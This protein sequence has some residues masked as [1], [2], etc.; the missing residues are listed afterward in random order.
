MTTASRRKWGIALI[1]VPPLC[2][3]GSLVLWP[4]LGFV[5][6]SGLLG[7]SVFMARVMNVLLGLIGIVGVAGLFIGVPIGL[8]LVF[9][10][11]KDQASPPAQQPPQTPPVV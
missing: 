8:Y 3:G 10:K 7:Y 5:Y 9:S 6:A 4:I 11:G 1:I 2:L